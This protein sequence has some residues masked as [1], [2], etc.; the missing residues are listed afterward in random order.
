M[1]AKSS[2][3]LIA[4]VL[5]LA[6]C[7]APP[8]VHVK[9]IAPFRPP[10]PDA[11]HLMDMEWTVWTPELMKT[12]VA[13]LETNAAVAEAYYALTPKSYEILASNMAEIK[14][15]IK[16]L[17]HLVFYYRQTADDLLNEESAKKE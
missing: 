10:M 13:D 2:A 4:G 17:Q 14:R 15:Y 1:R 11:V 7:V 8:T 12:Y 5:L 16:E 9:Y 3:I 6:G